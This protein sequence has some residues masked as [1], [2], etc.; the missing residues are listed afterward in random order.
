MTARTLRD[1]R[2]SNQRL[3]PVGV[4]VLSL[5]EL[6]R[7]LLALRL[8][9]PERVEFF[10]VMVVTRGRGE[11]HVDFDRIDLARGRVLFVRPGQ[12][13][14]W[15]LRSALQGQVLL[16]EPAALQARQG[17]RPDNQVRLTRLEEWPSSFDLDAAELSTC[18]QLVTMLR[19]E[20][21]AAVV[22]PLSAALAR[23]LLLCALLALSRPAHRSV[24]GHA[25]THPLAQR[26]TAELERRVSGRPTVDA[27]A[28]A[29]GVSTS[30]L[31]RVCC[32]AFGASAK[33]LI[34]RRIALEAQRLLVH[35]DATSVAIGEQLGFTEP[36]N[37]LKFFRRRVGVTPEAFRRGLR[38]SRGS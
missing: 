18:L 6:Q 5:S 4:E 38:P 35:T 34:D 11:H 22:T 16:I 24:R 20:L 1:T 3:D 23:Q 31:H 14:E 25:M 37:F 21:S 2:F 27:M 10:M 33:S 19:Q 12:V 30:T 36:T 13:Q 29:L 8:L 7:R 9:G 15:R 17:A 26:F 28:A 32:A